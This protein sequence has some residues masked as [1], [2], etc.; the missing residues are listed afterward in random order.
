MSYYQKQSYDVMKY[1]IDISLKTEFSDEF[2]YHTYLI[3]Q[4]MGAQSEIISFITKYHRI[5]N[6]NDAKAYLIRVKFFLF[7]FIASRFFFYRSKGFQKLSINLLINKFKDVIGILKCLG[8]FY[9][10]LLTNSKCFENNYEMNLI[11][12]KTIDFNLF[13]SNSI[14]FK[15]SSCCFY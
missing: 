8:L 15:S 1:F 14:Y 2:S 9:K 13:N 3:N 12:G 5:L 10:E 4:M 7:R 6:L 11:I